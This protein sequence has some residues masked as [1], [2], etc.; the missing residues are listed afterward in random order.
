LAGSLLVWRVINLAFDNWLSKYVEPPVI[1]ALGWLIAQPIGWVGLA[2]ALW[3]FTLLLLSYLDSS[4]VVAWLKI[5][6]SAPTEAELQTT[7]KELEQLRQKHA[8]PAEPPELPFGE[9]QRIQFVRVFWTECGRDSVHRAIFLAEKL[10][11]DF[12][13][14]DRL[15]DLLWT[16]IADLGRER[17]RL[18]DI[19]QYH[20]RTPH[21]EVMSFLRSLTEDYLAVVRWIRYCL[22]RFNVDLTTPPYADIAD[23][24]EAHQAY[25]TEI[26]RLAERPENEGFKFY[27]SKHINDDHF[28]RGEWA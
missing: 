19:L 2:L 14:A 26:I 25:K 1:S 13:N 4:K 11:H 16:P 24:P 20:P 21:S 3:V 15:V 8:P 23:W 6:F 9:L 17:D 7:R 5:R 28:G 12:H 10:R 27:L 22:D 18:N